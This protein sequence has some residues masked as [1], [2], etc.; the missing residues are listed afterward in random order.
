MTIFGREA[1]FP[2]GT[3]EW[4]QLGCILAVIAVTMLLASGW[5]TAL[6]G[7]GAAFAGYLYDH[8]FYLPIAIATAGLVALLLGVRAGQAPAGW[9]ALSELALLAGGFIAYE[10]GR[11]IFVGA[12][13]AA[14]ANADRIMAFER[15]LGLDIEPALQ[16][17]VVRH[18]ILV[19]RLNWIYSFAFLSLVLGTLF[20]LYV[21]NEGL[22]RTYRTSLGI[23]ALLALVTIALVPTAPPRLAAESG[24]LSTHELM[25]KSHGFVNQYAAMPSL[26]VGWVAL[27]GFML[28]R[29]ARLTLTR[30]FWA[31]VPVTVMLITVM[32]TGNHYWL[33]G[34]V[35]AAFALVPAVAL[36]RRA[37]EGQAMETTH[38]EAVEPRWRLAHLR[39][40]SGKA[41]F[42]WL[43]LGSLLLYLL[44]R[45]AV[46]PGFTDYWG[47]MV[48]Q[49]A[50]SIVILTWLDDEF[51]P[52]GGLSWF[53]H[54]VVVINTWADSLGTAAH[55]YDRY[56]S[57]DK[58]THFL[59]GVML[60]AAAADIIFAI[61]RRRNAEIVAVRVLTWA[62]CIS[63][64]LGAAWELYEFLGDRLFDTGRHAGALDTWY[65]LISD[66]VGSVVAA[67]VLFKWRGVAYEREQREIETVPN[68]R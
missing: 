53:T 43:F 59:G 40:A 44:V 63:V 33:D 13:E 8:H 36:T 12:A 67:F 38:E 2:I 56:V 26:H 32:A 60:T 23:S 15:R 62:I 48:G 51:A 25:G 29:S 7:V 47:Y 3:A 18:P 30:A 17:F 65:D 37:R 20:F 35:G 64:G 5:S 31:V 19:E 27:A 21:S 61:Q 34:A 11:S 57:Y 54:L 52:W 58:I 66:S 10:W 16:R 39:S 14:Q 42:S 46:D 9:R 41:R 1:H 50:L 28:S 4:I 24:M 55:M 49:I 45:Q 68:P 6:L 22:Y